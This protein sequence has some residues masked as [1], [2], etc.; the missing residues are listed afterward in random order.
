MSSLTDARLAQLLAQNMMKHEAVVVR[1][2]ARRRAVCP[3]TRK[4]ARVDDEIL[5]DGERPHRRSMPSELG[6]S[7][8]SP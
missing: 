2:V 6:L 4:R 8:E 1:A 5:K 3:R 7:K